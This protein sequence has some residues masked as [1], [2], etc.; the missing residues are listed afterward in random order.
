MLTLTD[1]I[2]KRISAL[3][4]LSFHDFMEMALYYP[5]LGYYTNETDKLGCDGDYYT[6]P[7]TGPLFGKLIAKQLEEMWDCM[8]KGTFTVVEYGAGTGLLCRDILSSLQ[9]NGQLYDHLQYCIIE[10]SDALRDRQQKILKEKVSWYDYISEI[11]PIRGC[12]LSNEL[13]DNFAVHVVEMQDELMELFI[14]ES[15]T[16]HFKPAPEKVKNYFTMLGI[17]LQKGQRTE[18]NLEAI[19]WVQDIAKALQKGFAMTIDYGFS[20][21]QLY[22]RKAGTLVCYH[23]HTM[24]E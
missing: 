13:L 20:S 6:S 8:G 17:A 1:I 7:F 14:D 2:R 21:E 12:I 16:E 18:V 22:S 23:K 11:A 10:K 5:G 15:F 4:L 19:Q 24:N 9:H 3:K